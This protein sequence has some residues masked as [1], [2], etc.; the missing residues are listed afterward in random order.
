MRCAESYAVLLI[1][2]EKN[3]VT[4]IVCGIEK[5]PKENASIFLWFFFIPT[6]YHYVIYLLQVPEA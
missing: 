1:A 6:A 3:E 5:E 2:V 4:H